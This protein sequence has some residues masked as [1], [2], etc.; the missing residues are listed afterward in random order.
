MHCSAGIHRT[1]MITL[2]LLRFLKYSE[3]EADS[4][5]NDLRPHTADGVGSH[6]R[7]WANGWGE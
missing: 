4:I 2:A 1:G 7:E 5:V 3:Q 6:R